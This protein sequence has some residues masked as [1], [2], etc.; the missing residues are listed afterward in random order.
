MLANSAP[1]S[2]NYKLN[3]TCLPQ[4]RSLE[5]LKAHTTCT[6]PYWQHVLP[7]SAISS[8]R[9]TL[10]HYIR[11]QQSV[12]LVAALQRGAEVVRWFAPSAWRQ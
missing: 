12:C 5:A 9:Q 1:Y 11:N 3:V 6:E 4:T 8:G 2:S 7:S 10:L